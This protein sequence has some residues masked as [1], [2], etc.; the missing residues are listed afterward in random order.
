MSSVAKPDKHNHAGR[1]DK[2]NHDERFGNR[3]NADKFNVIVCS[4]NQYKGRFASGNSTVRHGP[5][6]RAGRSRN[7]NDKH[8]K[9]HGEITATPIVKVVDGTQCAN[10]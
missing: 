2:H 4:V 5:K 10:L 8:G 7:H 1:P 6:H 9:N 3:L